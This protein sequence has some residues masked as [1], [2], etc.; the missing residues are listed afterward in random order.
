M[1]DNNLTNYKYNGS[2]NGKGSHS[3]SCLGCSWSHSE[4][5]GRKEQN[6]GQR[7]ANKHSCYDSSKDSWSGRK[8][9]D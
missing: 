7:K 3:W 2:V 9:L 6:R 8:D 5:G 1:D 4:I